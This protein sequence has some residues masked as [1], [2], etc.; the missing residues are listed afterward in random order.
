MKL[1]LKINDLK[2]KKKVNFFL[3][4]VLFISIFF[5][6]TKYFIFQNYLFYNQY[7]IIGNL[8][9]INLSKEYLINFY[10]VEIFS[11]VLKDF[12]ELEI[13]RYLGIVI[14]TF[15]L[16][17]LYIYLNLFNISLY[18]RFLI[19]VFFLFL[20]NFF[21]RY[22]YGHI[23]LMYLGQFFLCSFFIISYLRKNELIFLIFFSLL[24]FWSLLN[25][26]Q[27]SVY[28]LII[29]IFNIF[30]FRDEYNIK[31]F[32]KIFFLIFITILLYFIFD[33]NNIITR[34]A[35]FDLNYINKYSLNSPLD[36]YFVI[37]NEFYQ[38]FAK[39]FHSQ[40][41]LNY[42][43]K[44]KIY[45]KY[46]SINGPETT[47]FYGITLLLINIYV[48]FINH[49]FKFLSFII[50]F[51]FLFCLNNF[52]FFSLLPITNFFL[53][54]FRAVTRSLVIV[55]FLYIILLIN[56]FIYINSKI[57]Y[58]YIFN[59][60]IIFLIVISIVSNYNFGI[61]YNYSDFILPGKNYKNEIN[62]EIEKK[63]F[64]SYLSKLNPNVKFEENSSLKLDLNFNPQYKYIKQNNLFLIRKD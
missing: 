57:K 48:L 51:V 59:S 3:L 46:Y 7:D 37:N 58:P 4:F 22:H 25:S 29:L 33:Y 11:Y 10:L 64:E 19:L 53:P 16:I 49:K 30:Y 9:V 52:Y 42:F 40:S 26:I 8:Y 43:D 63:Y 47:F 35:T 62:K 5:Y 39:F 24:L 32:Y 13:Y 34:F 28:L 36:L 60:L 2:F 15:N 45:L 56:F 41:I 54:F 1:P 17:S 21:Y 55:D 44:F 50:L 31:S 38:L 61:K 14:L 6:Y 12:N 27:Y 23:T 20:P 18:E